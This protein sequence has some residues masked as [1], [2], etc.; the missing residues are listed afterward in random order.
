M[1]VSKLIKLLFFFTMFKYLYFLIVFFLGEIMTIQMGTDY[2]FY[3][4]HNKWNIRGGGDKGHQKK[5][6]SR[7][8]INI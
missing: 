2:M 3:R 5:F 1:F 8:E 6:D 4:Q 7:I